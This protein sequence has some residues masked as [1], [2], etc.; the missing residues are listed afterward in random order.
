MRALPS[1][2]AA[3]LTLSAAVPCKGGAPGADPGECTVSVDGGGFVC[4]GQPFPAVG[5]NCYYLMVYAT[6]PGLRRHVAEVLDEAK[7]LGATVVRTW[8]FNDGPGWNALQTAPGV[9]SER[10]FAGL[11]HVVH[12]AGARGLKVI[13]AL[14]NN[15]D[16]Y[17]GMRQY[18]EWSPSAA[19]HDDF[20]TDPQTKG[21]YR[22]HA[23]RVLGR[24][25][26]LSGLAYSE[27]P[28]IFAWE[29]ANEP[30]A[31]S[32][33][34]AALDAWIAEMS[35]HLKALDPRHMVSTGSE[36]FYGPLHADRNP[37]GWMA[38]EGVDFVANHSHASIDFASFHAYPD[39]WSLSIEA[40]AE[41]VRDH[42][43]DSRDLLGKPALLGEIGKREPL[44]LRNE[45]FRASYDAAIAAIVAA[46]ADRSAAGLL[47]WIL[48]HDEYPDYDGFGIYWPDARHADT[49]AIIEAGS[50]GIRAAIAGGPPFVRGDANCDGAI[51]ISDP[52]R[53]LTALFGGAG[54]LCC[55]AAADSDG[56]GALAVADS[57][58]SLAHLFTQGPPP[59][60]PYPGCGQ[61]PAP[62]AACSV[63]CAA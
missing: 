31:T 58:H 3:A 55:E 13:L 56:D 4:G 49:V 28:A 46:G 36:G 29:L 6:E 53:I 7:L 1:L 26:K 10:V 17:G 44:P 50:D 30:R 2:A 21:W 23:A 35:A 51:D 38:G 60:S 41:W 18:V 32:A 33:G 22:D 42:F 19:S 52:I 9:Y 25:N 15:W 5:F 43:A 11:D 61:G 34:R 16:D 20:Y 37:A 62:S 47:P 54:N 57:I 24:V 27:D 40:A 39:H 59:P 14:V 12:E 45:L 8:A 63:P 48:Y